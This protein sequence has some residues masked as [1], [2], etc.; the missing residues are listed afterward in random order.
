MKKA[1][2]RIAAAIAWPFSKLGA[3]RSVICCCLLAVVLMLA[4]PPW[5][6]SII[7]RSGKSWGTTFAGYH[8]FSWGSEY[9][10]ETGTR[11]HRIDKERLG[12]Q[13][14]GVAVVGGLL[15]VVLSNRKRH[16]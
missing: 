7:A 15:C 16:A 1:I 12:V 6:G 3:V 11:S 2:A 8:A 13:V 9:S 5:Y 4:F 14:L 10:S